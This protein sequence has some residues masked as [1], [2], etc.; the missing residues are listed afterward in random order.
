MDFLKLRD[1]TVENVSKHEYLVVENLQLIEEVTMLSFDLGDVNSMSDIWWQLVILL[2]PPWSVI[3]HLWK[4]WSVDS[5]L[6]TFISFRIRGRKVTLQILVWSDLL[7]LDGCFVH[8][9]LGRIL[10][11]IEIGEELTEASQLGLAQLLDGGLILGNWPELW[12]LHLLFYKN[13][14]KWIIFADSK[15]PGDLLFH[16][17]INYLKL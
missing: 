14:E 13:V 3:C 4:P 5:L 16:V 10:A 9:I 17:E 7:H 15:F 2:V 12:L 1:A 11:A 8:C 6:P